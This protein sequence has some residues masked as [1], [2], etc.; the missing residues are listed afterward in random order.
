MI[1]EIL[2]R[3]KKVRRTGPNNWLACCPAHDDN[4]PSLTLHSSDT[5]KIVAR[6][7]AEC[8]FG[9][10]VDGVG[11]GYEPWFPPKQDGDFSPPIKRPFP[12]ADVLRAVADEALILSVFIHDM[13]FAVP[14]K[15][16]DIDRAQLAATRIL[17]A[18]S[19]ALGE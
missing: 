19:L 2:E 16:D 14:L 18:R 12:A 13:D 5:G 8:S 15:Q 10:I 7:F 3:L 11:L 6:C 17:A 4:N 1:D 9:A